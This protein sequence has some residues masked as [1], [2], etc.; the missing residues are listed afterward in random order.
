MEYLKCYNRIDIA[1]DS[2][3]VTGGTT[4]FEASYMG[5]PT[6]TKISENNAW[7]KSGVSINKN[8][9]MDDWIAK[10][11]K[12][13]ISKALKFSENKKN[14]INLKKELKNIAF[15][16]PLF[17]SVNFSNDFYEMLLNVSKKK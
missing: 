9:N 11:E 15:K 4:S 7:F 14:L 17:D 3:P 6:L 2:F 13:Y 12:E 16:S 5:V 1:L 8:L 10:N